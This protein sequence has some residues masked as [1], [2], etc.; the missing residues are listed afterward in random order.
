M[1][2][3]NKIRHCSKSQF[4]QREKTDCLLFWSRMCVPKCA[5]PVTLNSFNLCMHFFSFYLENSSNIYAFHNSQREKF[6]YLYKVLGTF[7]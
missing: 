4:Q 7:C 2:L 5:E 1:N 3:E 6:T